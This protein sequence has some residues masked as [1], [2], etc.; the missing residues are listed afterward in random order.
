MSNE[1]P[2]PR[3]IASVT[4]NEPPESVRTLSDWLEWRE[5]EHERMLHELG[6]QFVAA[7]ELTHGDPTIH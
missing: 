4:A 3:I 5:R 1:K 6:E 2:K 7:L